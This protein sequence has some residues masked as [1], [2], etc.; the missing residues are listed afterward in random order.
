MGHL[1]G[2]AVCPE[3]EGPGL[4]PWFMSQGD[5]TDGDSRGGAE[6]MSQLPAMSL[7]FTHLFYTD[8]K[9]GAI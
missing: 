8:L 9:F 7:S 6:K 2:R 3:G 1:G 4:A 5:K